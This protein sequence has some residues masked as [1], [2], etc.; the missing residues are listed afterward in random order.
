[1][2]GTGAKG[3]EWVVPRQEENKEEEEIMCTK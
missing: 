3:K 2:G 1:M